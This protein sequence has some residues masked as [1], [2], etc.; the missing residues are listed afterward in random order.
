MVCCGNENQVNKNLSVCFPRGPTSD[1]NLIYEF[2][3][4]NKWDLR[5]YTNESPLSNGNAIIR[6]L[7]SIMPKW[8]NYTSRSC[9]LMDSITVH[10]FVKVQVF[11]QS[12][13]PHVTMEK[14]KLVI[15]I[16]AIERQ[17]Q[18]T[19]PQMHFSNCR[20]TIN[21]LHLK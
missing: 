2:D 20:P 16:C 7:C 10:L 15:L 8:S 17:P 14:H 5:I 13:D 19:F 4:Y 1:N 12:E 11:H 18:S 21:K 9:T 3:Q 6:I